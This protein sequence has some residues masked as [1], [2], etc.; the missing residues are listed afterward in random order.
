MGE[1]MVTAHWYICD[2]LDI[3]GGI[4]SRVSITIKGTTSTCITSTVTVQT[5]PGRYVQGKHHRLIAPEAQ[6]D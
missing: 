2:F 1:L 3:H 5:A 4:A 6:D